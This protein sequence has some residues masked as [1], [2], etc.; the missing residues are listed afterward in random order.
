MLHL[1]NHFKHVSTER[2]CSGIGLT[3]IYTFLK[4]DGHG[5][6][7]NWL[8]EQLAAVHDPV[9]VIV[10]AAL[11][12]DRPCRLCQATL[13]MFVSILGA[14]A[15]NLALKMLAS[16]GIYLGGGIPPRILPA[17]QKSPFMEAFRHKGRM[18]GLMEDIPVHMILNPRVAL[19]GAACHGLWPLTCENV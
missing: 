3:N 2:V 13:N 6:E 8:A 14:E 17:L 18:S 1:L 4:E 16:G 11:D 5:E 15:G 12:E 9:P 10:N 19:M 7:P